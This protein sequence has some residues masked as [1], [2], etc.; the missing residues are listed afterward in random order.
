MIEPNNNNVNINRPKNYK[1]YV[2]TDLPNLLKEC[3]LDGLLSSFDPQKEY[4][5]C[6]IY[7]IGYKSKYVKLIKA[8]LNKWIPNPADKLNNDDIFDKKTC[9]LL[10][11]FNTRFKI[12]A[13]TGEVTKETLKFFVHIAKN[14]LQAFLNS[15]PNKYHLDDTTGYA[16]EVLRKY[17]SE[18]ALRKM[19]SGSHKKSLSTRF[20]Y[21]FNA[22]LM[23]KREKIIRFAKSLLG[24]DYV[25]AEC[26]PAKGFDCSGFVQY[27]F[28]Q[29]GF[30]KMSR[31]ADCQEYGCKKINK[32]ELL[33]GDLVF[34]N[35]YAPG[36]ASHVAIYIGNNEII[37]CAHGAGEVVISNLSESYYVTHYRSAGRYIS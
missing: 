34:F 23:E 27:V 6:K 33:P 35:G 3:G 31:T 36:V 13:K 32:N 2:I 37:H 19:T 17:G 15:T 26:T 25:W 5:V 20:G 30:K 11:F 8:C 21:F 1:G 22:Y 12:N 10:S 29:N 18:K 16:Y 24:Y 9:G 4:P 14:S 7:T 28:K